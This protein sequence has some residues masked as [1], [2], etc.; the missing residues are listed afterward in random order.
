MAV[1]DRETEPGEITQEKEQPRRTRNAKRMARD[2]F[3]PQNRWAAVLGLFMIIRAGIGAFSLVRSAVGFVQ[4][5]EDRAAAADQERFAEFIK[6]LVMF[7][8]PP[9]ETPA[10]LDKNCLL[11]ACVWLA[12]NSLSHPQY[13]ELQYML[14]PGADV[15]A[16]CVTLFGNDVS[17]V[18]QT[19][20]HGGVTMEYDAVKGAYHIPGLSGAY[21][22]QI[23]KITRKGG[24]VILTV[25]YLEPEQAGTAAVKRAIYSLSGKRGS[26]TICS[27][28]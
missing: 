19:F 13:D 1:T 5:R 22:P 16:A 15:K 7:D 10:A 4:N 26:E 27:C 24:T 14:V 8:P 11:R 17:L 18:P 25:G 21:T 28:Q 12:M 3:M 6:P 23:E 2:P 20:S 9:F